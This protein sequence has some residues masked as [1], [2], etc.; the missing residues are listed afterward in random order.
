ML[1]ELSDEGI[2]KFPP[3]PEK[4]ECG[5]IYI[6]KNKESN[7]DKRKIIKIINRVGSP[8]KNRNVINA[9]INFI[10]KGEF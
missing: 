5:K 1:E 4:F 9:A 6:T 7:K 2:A 10:Y 3:I 8:L